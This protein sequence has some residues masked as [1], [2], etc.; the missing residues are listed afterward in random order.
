MLGLPKISTCASTQHAA[1]IKTLQI[2]V[3]QMQK[4]LHSLRER[5]HILH[6]AQSVPHKKRRQKKKSHRQVAVQTD[7]ERL[8]M[9]VDAVDSDAD[10]ECV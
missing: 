9:M 3:Y 6:N 10:F 7:Y 4:E 5:T 8:D 1:Q 2:Q